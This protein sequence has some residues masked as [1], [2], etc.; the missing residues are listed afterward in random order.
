M[1]LPD[2]ETILAAIAAPIGD[3][4]PCG[5]DLRTGAGVNST[6]SALRDARSAARMQERAGD[7][8]PERAIG[9]PE[10]WRTVEAL[11]IEALTTET[12]DLEIAS[13]LAESLAR[14]GGLAGLSLGARIM[15][16]LVESFWSQGLYPAL[17]ADDPEARTFAVSGLSGSDRDGSLIQ[18]LRKTIL[19]ELED[20]RPIAFW[21]YERAR[22][23]AASS[24]QGEHIAVVHD[25]LPS[26]DQMESA[27]RGSGNADLAIVAR[28][29]DAAYAAWQKLNDIFLEV[30]QDTVPAAEAPSMGRVANILGDIRAAAHRY[31]V[32]DELPAND[33]TED[34]GD[35][36]DAEAVGGTTAE[37]AVPH[38]HARPTRS[39]LLD[40]AMDIAQQFREMEPHSPFS[41]TL[42]NAVRRA[43][44]SLP[45]LLREVVMDD[46]SRI[47]ILTRLGIQEL[48]V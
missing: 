11:A 16:R 15:T 37:A 44:L 10:E 21:E 33:V 1:L 27:A 40:A 13:A 29:A 28:H 36:H 45:D 41:Y 47:E 48:D 31:V 7:D 42:E 22:S 34:P 24:A 19:F 18:P 23:R 6:Y 12:K 14:R 17:E 20:G 43:R 38:R 39:E 26:L 2:E 32:P 25:G 3:A 46:S 9:M 4:M 5:R 30:C 8:D 35:L